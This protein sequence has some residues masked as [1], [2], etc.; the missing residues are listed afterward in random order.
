MRRAEG[1]FREDL[2]LKVTP[3][4]AALASLAREAG[5]QRAGFVDPV[6]LSSW[7]PRWHSLQR[8]S[9]SSSAL[10]EAWI[11]SPDDWS[12]R[13]AILVCCLSCSRDEPDDLSTPGDP[14]A[15]VAPF[16]RAHYYRAAT[17]LLRSLAATIEKD[18]G[19]PRRATHAR[20][21][22][23]IFS[24]SRIPEKPLLVASGLGA[25][26][27]NG[28]CIVPGLGSLFVIAGIVIPL[29]AASLLDAPVSPAADPCG[30]CERCLHAC[31]TG[32]LVAP[33]V[34]DTSRCLQAKAATTAPFDGATLE[35]W[36][37]RLYGCQDC[38]DCCPHNAGLTGAEGAPKARA[39]REQGPTIGEVGPSI[40]LRSLL[41]MDAAKR[42]ALFRG[43]AMGMSWIPDAAIVRNALVAAGSRGEASLA[44]DVRRYAD[45]EEPGVRAAARWA[46]GRLLPPSLREK[47]QDDKDGDKD[48][49]DERADAGHS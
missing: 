17:G 39:A 49:Q 4:A 7:A 40:S 34:L 42:R 13:S 24:N 32:A 2:R 23:R 45:A 44:S 16:A 19:V 22:V 28:L 27:K 8:D 48:V 3:A 30:R 10:E 41:S 25:M 46:L 20:H 29:P 38:Q 1:R 43:T 37:T 15:R 5:F 12:R 6:L 31:P 9:G 35:A 21:A 47:S 33:G 14:H 11:L 26:G 36:G 18:Y